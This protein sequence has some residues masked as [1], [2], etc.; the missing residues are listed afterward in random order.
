MNTY[1]S[2]KYKHF[3]VATRLPIKRIVFYFSYRGETNTLLYDQRNYPLK[4]DELEFVHKTQPK[5]EKKT[6]KYLKENFLS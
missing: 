6:I 2:E 4:K 1:T 3:T 5:F